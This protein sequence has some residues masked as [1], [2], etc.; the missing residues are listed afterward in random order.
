[1]TS[2]LQYTDPLKRQVLLA[3]RLALLRAIRTN[4]SAGGA[5][6]FAQA[7]RTP[8]VKPELKQS[9]SRN[10]SRAQ[11]NPTLKPQAQLKACFQAKP[12]PCRKT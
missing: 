3:L 11:G 7:T 10:R 1:M 4:M 12:Q 9:Q 2:F 6:C 8:M 5:F